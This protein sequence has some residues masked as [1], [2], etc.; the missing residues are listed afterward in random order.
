MSFRFLK[1]NLEGYARPRFTHRGRTGFFV[2]GL[3]LNQTDNEFSNLKNNA[4]H[5]ADKQYAINDKHVLVSNVPQINTL[6][7]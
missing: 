5:P 7:I 3:W 6:R 2:F 4:Q 1:N